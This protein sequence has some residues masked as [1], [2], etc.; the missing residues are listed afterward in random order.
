[1][2]SAQSVENW[3]GWLNIYDPEY[4]L[5]ELTVEEISRFIK[6]SKARKA[7]GPDAICMELIKILEGDNL[8]SFALLL[9]SWWREGV[10][11]PS[12]LEALVVSLYKKG[13]PR[14]PD[15]YRPITL[16][17]AFYMIYAGLIK[18]RLES[19]L[20][21][22]L[23]KCQFGFRRSMSTSQAIFALRRSIDWSE[24]SGG[25]MS[26]VPPLALP[27]CGAHVCAFQRYPR[28]GYHGLC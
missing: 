28:R 25:K 27:F 4:E 17:S 6:K 10:V 13:D 24:R 3:V 16:L 1:M 22:E 14:I 15:S 9:Y 18:V 19:G 12:L 2:Q 20:E 21:K 26:G 11:P 23:S 7:P 8:T 5:G